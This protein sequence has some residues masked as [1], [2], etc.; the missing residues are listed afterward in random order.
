[1][2][3]W[4]KKRCG[5]IAKK[6]TTNKKTFIVFFMVKRYFIFATLLQI[7]AKYLPKK[8]KSADHTAVTALYVDLKMIKLILKI[9]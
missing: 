6:N 9:Q 3:R 2:N 4:C 5:V 7:Y 8:N 1:V